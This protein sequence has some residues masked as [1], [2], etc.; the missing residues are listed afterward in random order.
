M[1]AS[2]QLNGC[3]Q[4]FTRKQN[5]V[6]FL[7]QANNAIIF[8]T[9][10]D[11]GS[12]TSMW[13][14]LEMCAQTGHRWHET[15][16]HRRTRNSSFRNCTLRR[17][18]PGKLLARTRAKWLH[19]ND[20][21]TLVGFILARVSRR[22]Y[23]S[24]VADSSR[25]RLAT[26]VCVFFLVITTHNLLVVAAKNRT[27]TSSRNPDLCRNTIIYDLTKLESVYIPLGHCSETWLCRSGSEPT[28][29]HYLKPLE[30]GTKVMETRIA[31]FWI[32]LCQS[33]FSSEY[34]AAVILTCWH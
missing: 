15:E 10:S 34:I 25:D 13:V 2:Y 17:S 6:L 4:Y 7:E 11:M 22:R 1:S 3:Y 20:I 8:L 28:P 21:C 31:S 27:E 30:I 16:Q 5:V 18:V 12:H 23:L 32:V 19:I 14:W 33:K 24:N 26:S 29:I 9:T